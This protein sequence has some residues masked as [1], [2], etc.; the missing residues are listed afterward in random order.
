[1]RAGS[2]IVADASGTPFK[3]TWIGMTD[4]I[5]ASKNQWLHIGG[6]T[7]S[8]GVRR[9]AL[10]SQVAFFAGKVGIQTMDLGT[11]AL[12]VNGDLAVTGA[13]HFVIDHPLAPDDKQLRH[14]SLEGPEPAVFYRGEARLSGGRATVTLP[15]YFEAL[16]Q[17]QGRTV[18]VTPKIDRDEPACALAVSTVAD[19]VFHVC[20]IGHDNPVQAFFW[21]VKAVRA[22][23]GDYQA[24]IAKA[25]TTT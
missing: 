1:V 20:A 21:E 3:D 8:D 16:T 5:D 2:F 22:N 9:T 4:W 25:K 19:G 14:T 18:Q 7:G 13:K 24:E 23:V 11:N 6:I 17:P 15:D 10:Y 12:V